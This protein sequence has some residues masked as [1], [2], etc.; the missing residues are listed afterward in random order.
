MF[1][2]HAALSAFDTC[3]VVSPA[4]EKYDDNEEEANVLDIARIVTDMHT[5]A[6]V[7]EPKCKPWEITKDGVRDEIEESK[8]RKSTELK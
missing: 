8:I 3:F 6:H 1:H 5:H 4:E 7:E 2:A